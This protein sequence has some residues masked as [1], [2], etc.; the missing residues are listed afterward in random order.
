M[1]HL[2]LG[3]GIKALGLREQDQWGS[4]SGFNIENFNLEIASLRELADDIIVFNDANK[5]K[6]KFLKWMLQWS[7]IISG[8]T[9]LISILMDY[10]TII[11]HILLYTSIDIN[12]AKCELIGVQLQFSEAKHLALGCRLAGRS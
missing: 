8:Q 10:P 6:V 2:T 3:I 12:F 5:D 4:F 7:E 11:N 9:I 1:S